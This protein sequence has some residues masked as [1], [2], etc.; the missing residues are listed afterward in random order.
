MFEKQFSLMEH[1]YQGGPICGKKRPADCHHALVRAEVIENWF[2]LHHSVFQEHHLRQS[3]L[4]V[5]ANLLMIA[6]AVI[7]CLSSVFCALVA[8]RVKHRNRMVFQN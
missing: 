7:E 1:S 8:E 5:F 3:W 6:F 2:R 4:V